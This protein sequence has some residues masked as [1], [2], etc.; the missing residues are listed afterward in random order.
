MGDLLLSV[1]LPPSAQISDYAHAAEG[2]GCHRLWL[3]DSPALY[4]DIWIAASRA[5]SATRT[6]GVGTGV[7]VPALRHPM[8]TAA[9]IATLEEQ[10]PGRLVCAF[11]TGFTPRRAMGQKPM[12][13]ASVPAYL[14]HLPGLLGGDLADID[15]SPR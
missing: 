6:L 12:R 9:A 14:T 3:F 2:A 10:A 7:A 11:G 13:W 5:A 15:T 1:A 8:V 4:G